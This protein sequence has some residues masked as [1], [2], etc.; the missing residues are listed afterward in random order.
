MQ[1]CTLHP[2]RWRV[3]V[4][5]CVG[6]SGRKKC[7]LKRWQVKEAEGRDVVFEGETLSKNS[8]GENTHMPLCVLAVLWFAFSAVLHDGDWCTS[9]K[10]QCVVF[11]SVSG[12]LAS[13]PQLSQYSTC[14]R[15]RSEICKYTVGLIPQGL[16]LCPICSLATWGKKADPHFT[17]TMSV[18]W[19]KTCKHKHIHKSFQI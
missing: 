11:L 4:G 14:C 3:S 17:V 10:G 13:A 16:F 5:V 1:P 12:R 2:D 19:R 18:Y 7:V 15:G 9:Q 6:V 8:S